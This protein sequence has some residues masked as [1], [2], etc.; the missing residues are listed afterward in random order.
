MMADDPTPDADGILKKVEAIIGRVKTPDDDPPAGRSVPYER[1]FAA[2]QRAKAAE[3]ALTTLRADVEALQG[4][5]KTQLAAAKAEVAA[6]VAK[7]GTQ[8]QQDLALVDLGLD[9]DGRAEVRRVWSGLPEA[10][11]PK[12][13]VD[14]W[15]AALGAHK[16]HAED[17]EKPAPQLPRTLAGYLPQPEREPETGTAP[18]SRAPTGGLTIGLTTDRG[19]VET[20]AAAKG[21]MAK[22]QGAQS[23]GDLMAALRQS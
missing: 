2:N 13:P 18:V 15:Q 23:W 17:P 19:R 14:Y 22:V 10:S 6:E 11:R 4:A 21:A 12:S 16:A 7:L 5:S 9:A 8:H 3:E 20:P 1:F